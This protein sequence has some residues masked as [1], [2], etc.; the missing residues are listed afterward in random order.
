MNELFKFGLNNL[1]K[2]DNRPNKNLASVFLAISSLIS[3]SEHDASI[4]IDAM[5]YCENKDEIWVL[6]PIHK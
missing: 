6:P 5:V 3:I 2:D 1:P 4:A